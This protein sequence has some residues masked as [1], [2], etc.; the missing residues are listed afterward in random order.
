MKRTLFFWLEKLKIAPGERKAITGLLVLL[1]L[2]GGLNLALSPSVPF[3]DGNYLE[4]EQQFA[5]RT[6]MLKAEEEK[7][8]EQ[9]FPSSEKQ[10][11]KAHIDTVTED[12]TS[13]KEVDDSEKEVGGT[14]QN[15]GIE[16]INVNTA[17]IEALKALPGIGPAYA[18]RIIKY[19]NESGNFKSFEELKN[20][21]GIAQK[22]LD[23]LMPFIKLKDSE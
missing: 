9:Y 18:K 6:A 7:L 15:T 19:R 22:R 1:I 14:G 11:A 2:L 13:N 23:K 4:L 20:I 17:N 12:S 10:I 5:E 3:E 21:K 8:M 16:R